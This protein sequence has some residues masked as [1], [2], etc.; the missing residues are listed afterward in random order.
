MLKNGMGVPFGGGGGGSE[1]HCIL[2]APYFSNNFL[3]KSRSS[4]SLPVASVY[5][6][7]PQSFGSPPNWSVSIVTI[8]G[9]F[10]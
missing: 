5:V 6:S 2:P 4:H 8:G 3:N 10:L 1:G 9:I 7:V